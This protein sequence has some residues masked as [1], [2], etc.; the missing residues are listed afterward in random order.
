MA[1]KNTTLIFSIALNGYQIRYRRHLESQRRYAEKM[2]Y[3][4]IVVEKPWVTNLGAECCWL[5]LYLLRAALTAG[6]QYVLFV[7]ADAYIQNDCPELTSLVKPDKFLFMAKGYSGKLNSGVML[8]KSCPESIAWLDQIINAIHEPV[9]DID[10]VGW[11]ENGHVIHFAK[12]CDG[13]EV[14]NEKWNNT[15]SEQCE[16]YIRHFNYGPMKSSFLDIIFHRI[17][18]KFSKLML[19]CNL[20]KKSE[21]A[22]KLKKVQERIPIL[23]NRVISEYKV[24]S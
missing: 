3:E 12:G 17:V 11:G 14:I 16:D 15:R 9:S 5:K 13:L 8:M 21:M 22:E 18:F 2:G 20:N 23:F 7:D 10:T 24:F 6:Y 19:R 1:S 4:Y